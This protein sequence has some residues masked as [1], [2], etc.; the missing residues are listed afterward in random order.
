M[1]Q[2]VDPAAFG[3]LPETTVP[4]QRNCPVPREVDRRTCST[5]REGLF[6][7]AARCIRLNHEL[8]VVVALPG[9]IGGVVPPNVVRR[10]RGV[11]PGSVA[12]D[13]VN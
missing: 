6:A 9:G 5:R 10:T 3:A 13:V 8:D 7:S 12:V 11:R 1:R 2:L 4:G